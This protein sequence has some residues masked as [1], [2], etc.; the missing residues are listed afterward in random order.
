MHITRQAIP[1][2]KEKNALD[3][4]GCNTPD[5]RAVGV[6][7][8]VELEKRERLVS[9]R[10]DQVRIIKVEATP[11]GLLQDIPHIAKG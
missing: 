5:Q 6:A 9:C 2:F 10:E 1:G 11:S 7:V 4:R 3:K 8:G